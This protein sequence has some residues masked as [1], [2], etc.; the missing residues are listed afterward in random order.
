VFPVK[1]HVR[2]SISHFHILPPTDCPYKTDIYFFTI[3]CCLFALVYR[4]SARVVSGACV[5]SAEAKMFS[6]GFDEKGEKDSQTS[7]DGVTGI[8]SPRVTPSKHSVLHPP[9]P[10]TGVCVTVEYLR[11][12]ET[13]SARESA[14]EGPSDSMWAH[15]EDTGTCFDPKRPRSAEMQ[16]WRRR[17][18]SLGGSLSV[19]YVPGAGVGTEIEKGTSPRFPNHRRLFYL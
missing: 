7:S 8:N 3:R 10:A 15:L 2:V 17:L 1:R 11:A 12:V 6:S 19:T 16:F 5:L 14:G 9:G 18:R 4:A 13:H